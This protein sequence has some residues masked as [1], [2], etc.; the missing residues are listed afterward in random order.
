MASGHVRKR[1]RSADAIRFQTPDGCFID[2]ACLHVANQGEGPADGVGGG[3][4]A[5]G[6]DCINESRVAWG[7]Q[8]AR[9]TLEWVIAPR[10]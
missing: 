6:L 4:A 8:L 9:D 1:P 2:R 3:V 7:V 5:D 10:Q